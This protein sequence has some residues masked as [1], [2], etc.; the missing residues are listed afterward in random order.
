MITK[1]SVS[2]Y[3]SLGPKTVIE[4][5]NLT[6][7]VGRNGAGKSNIIDLIK[8]VSD[9]MKMGLEGAITKRHG[10]KAI[11]RWS[12]GKPNN[13]AI[14]ID[15]KE[16]DFVANY[17]FS[18]SSHKKHEYIVSSESANIVFKNQ[19]TAAFQIIDQKWQS[20][21]IGLQPIITP[22]N[23]V[24]PLIS[25][26]ER[27]AK[28]ELALRNMAIYN[29]FPDTLRQPQIYDPQKPMNE[30]GKN[31]ASVLKDQDIETWKDD[32]IIGLKALTQEIDDIKI[33]QLSGYLIA[34][35][36]H[37]QTGDNKK[38]KWFD[39]SQESDGTLRIAGIITALLQTPNLPLIGIE[40]PELTIHP[41]A[42]PLVYD[43]L[44]QVSK[45]SQ[46][47]VTTHSPEL[48]DCIKISDN[49]RVVRK[50][51]NNT[52]ITAMDSKQVEAVRTGLL[53]LG[54]IHRQEGIRGAEQLSIKF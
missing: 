42:I 3:K 29:I 22:L 26:D 46:V 7:F 49:I 14:S 20:G 16:A 6:V 50:E 12:S 39:A 8:F 43:F 19:E 25:G 27:F 45:K 32:L 18:I 15:V 52:I 38:A 2:N 23:L 31:W 30:H 4:L 54:E 40:E 21:P 53:S 17:S 11:G 36:R 47:V 35:F 9:A 44:V 34:R 33:E 24:L 1:I 51:D 48:L 28:L 5:N 13:I 41:G 37:G 10:I